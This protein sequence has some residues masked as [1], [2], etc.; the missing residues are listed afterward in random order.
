LAALQA[1]ELT[2]EQVDEITQAGRT[3]PQRFFKGV[4][5]QPEQKPAEK[6]SPS[7]KSKGL[8]L[9]STLM[10]VAL[11]LLLLPLA[12]ASPA[13]L[14]G[15]DGLGYADPADNGGKLLTV[16]VSGDVSDPHGADHN[17]HFHPSRSPKTPGLRVLVNP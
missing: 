7:S 5:L 13:M 14:F 17:L 11:F 4:L 10:L 1:P 15:R 16:S 3:S 8:P 9:G 2:S 6:K 12:M